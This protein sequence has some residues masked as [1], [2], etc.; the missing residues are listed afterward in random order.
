M[1]NMPKGTMTVSDLGKGAIP[2]YP[3]VGAY[4]IVYSFPSGVQGI[5]I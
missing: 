3:K 1:G 5:Y 4:Q 2:S